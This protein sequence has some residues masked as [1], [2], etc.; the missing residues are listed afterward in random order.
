[1]DN[2]RGKEAW[3]LYYEPIG[4]YR[5]GQVCDF[6]SGE[7]IGVVEF[8]KPKLSVVRLVKTKSVD[9]PLSLVESGLEQGEKQVEKPKLKTEQVESGLDLPLIGEEGQRD[10]KVE[11][12]TDSFMDE[13]QPEEGSRSGA[14]QVDN[15]GSVLLTVDGEEEQFQLEV[16]EGE[17]S[18]R[19]RYRG[20]ILGLQM[21]ESRRVTD[22]QVY[23]DSPAFLDEVMGGNENCPE[24]LKLLHRQAQNFVGMFSR[25]DFLSLSEEASFSEEQEVSTSTEFKPTQ[26]QAEALEK[27]QSWS[28]QSASSE[29]LDNIFLLQGYAGTGKSYI[30]AQWLSALPR[31]KV[32]DMVYTAPTHKALGVGRSMID[33]VGVEVEVRTLQS[34]LKVKKV[35]DEKTNRGVFAYKG[36]SESEINDLPDFILVD[37]ASMLDE[38]YWG[39]LKDLAQNGKKIL[40]IGDAAQIR[41]VKGSGKSP[42]FESQLKNQA[43]LTEVVRYTTQQGYLATA[44]RSNQQENK[45]PILSSP[46][47]SVLALSS[48]DW[49]EAIAHRVKNPA[50]HDK[51]DYFQAYAYTN[52]RVDELNKIVR[53]ILWG[54]EPP[55]YVVGELIVAKESVADAFS[56]GSNA[57]DNEQEARIV[58]LYP[59]KTDK[60]GISCWMADIL[61]AGDDRPQSGTIKIVTSGDRPKLEALLRSEELAYKQ[62]SDPRERA[63]GWKQFEKFKQQ[64]GSVKYAYAA[65]F[66]AAQGSTKDYVAV[67]EQSLTEHF[68]ARYANVDNPQ[69]PQ[70]LCAQRNE[71]L[72]VAITRA[73]FG[74]IVF[75]ERAEINKQYGRTESRI[76]YLPEELQPVP[77]VQSSPLEVSLKE[78]S[79]SS[80]RLGVSA[81]ELQAQRTQFVA[82]ILMDLL[83]FKLSDRYE[84]QKYVAIFDSDLQTLSCYRAGNKQHILQASYRDG[85]WRSHFIPSLQS[86]QPNLSD[87]DLNFFEKELVPYLH[88]SQTRYQDIYSGCYSQLEPRE[89]CENVDQRVGMFLVDTGVEIE[90]IAQ[91]INQSPHFKSLSPSEAIQYRQAIIKQTRNYSRERNKELPSQQMEL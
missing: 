63:K 27:L 67:D 76:W 91:V 62:L 13:M 41:P 88:Q 37:E 14:I 59:P 46:D 66:H 74:T 77:I 48:D 22:L 85:N 17:I 35:Y 11:L 52:K 12:M 4:D 40:L 45:D 53:E 55:E 81:E 80:G 38:M 75:N 49:L 16:R 20:L 79:P 58:A 61:V 57:L 32:Q 60:N 10:E 39:G 5:D 19:T 2:F 65:T 34:L 78:E 1:L 33:K 31:S 82:P 42:I 28:S 84:G 24:S 43:E 56:Y 71:L 54:A 86:N 83:N 89:D 8:D 36:L 25:C 90:Q 23:C 87:G 29:A 69:E 73:R 18:D 68:N 21:A 30:T 72:Y 15:S 7:L 3:G 9:E 47:G 6:R 51:L 26:Q 44:L 64:Y 70:N 50:F